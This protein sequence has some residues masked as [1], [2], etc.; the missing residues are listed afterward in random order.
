VQSPRSCILV[1]LV[2]ATWRAFDYGDEAS[3]EEWFAECRGEW[4]AGRSL[5]FSVTGRRG[6]M[7]MAP[8]RFD[9]DEVVHLELATPAEVEARS[10][11]CQP[12]A[13]FG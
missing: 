1:E 6:L 4:N 10:V 9:A 5:I 12:A 2:D 8:S 11:S 7:T 13:L 3:A